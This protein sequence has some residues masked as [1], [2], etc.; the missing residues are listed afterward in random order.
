MGKNKVNNIDDRSRYV[1]LLFYADNSGH[2]IILDKIKNRN[3]FDAKT[4]WDYIGICHNPDESIENQKKHYHLYLS[5]KNPMWIKS[6]CKQFGF[7]KDNG[8]P[9]DQFVRVI[10]GKFEDA[11]P[12]LTH[13][14][15][16]DKELYLPTDLFGSPDMIAQYNRAALKYLSKKIDKR[17][18]Y[19]QV[20]D[21]IA[22][23][24]DIITAR[25]MV[26][27]LISHECFVIRHESWLRS[28]WFE[29]NSRLAYLARK[30]VSD[31]ICR[32]T[33]RWAE[34]LGDMDYKIMPDEWFDIMGGRT[35]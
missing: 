14:N 27:Y 8:D 34:L 19:K 1:K 5:F 7:F 16:P 21:W 24:Q 35:F 10:S 15:A 28:L 2:M 32:D 13:L 17:D 31:A 4:V 3:L 11:L 33:E 18:A 23:R 29:H 30:E 12:Y 26:N 22:S 6:I 20:S 25:D 9:D